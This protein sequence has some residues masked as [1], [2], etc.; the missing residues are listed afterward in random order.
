MSEAEIA[1]VEQFIL[2]QLTTDD[3][4]SANE[5]LERAVSQNAPFVASDITWGLLHLLSARKIE[6]TPAFAVRA[7]RVQVA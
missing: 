4:L 5:L 2:E 6:I 3:T 7:V 1:T